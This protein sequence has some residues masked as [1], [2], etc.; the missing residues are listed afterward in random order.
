MIGF[1]NFAAMANGGAVEAGERHNG[2]TPAL[3]TERGESLNVQFL[4]EERV[5]KHLRGHHST[6]ST[7]SV[8][9]Y[10]D[11]GR[12]LLCRIFLAARSDSR[13]PLH[14]CYGL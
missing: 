2:R 1:V 8:C 12:S 6:L 7:P 11:H 3:D 14:V 9:A 4:A 10:F 13:R 5:R